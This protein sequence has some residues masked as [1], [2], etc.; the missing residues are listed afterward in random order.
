MPRLL[1]GDLNFRMLIGQAEHAA[2][3]SG[4]LS[5][6]KDWAAE[7]LVA[8]SEKFRRTKRHEFRL[9]T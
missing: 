4:S 3:L 6:P 8:A 1:N 5:C 2:F 7:V 9:P